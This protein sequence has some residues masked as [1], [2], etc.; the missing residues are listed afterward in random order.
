MSLTRTLGATGIAL[1]LTLAGAGVASAAQSADGWTPLQWAQQSATGTED[2]ADDAVTTGPESRPARGEG[3]GRGYGMREGGT[4]DPTTCPYADDATADRDQDRLRERD[5]L[6]TPGGDR[7]QHR[8][9]MHAS[10]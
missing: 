8:E 1:G 3:N 9:R 2:G 10:S 7:E 4:G 5:G 6:G